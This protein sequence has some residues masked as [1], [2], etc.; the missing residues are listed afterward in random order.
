MHS[1]SLKTIPFTI[2]LL[3]LLHFTFFI[4]FRF[5]ARVGGGRGGNLLLSIALIFRSIAGI[6]T[7]LS[8]SLFASRFFHL[9]L[10]FLRFF[11]FLSEVR[12]FGVTLRVGC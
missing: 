11:D 8:F 5:R 3:L 12:F 2:T 6:I 4:M 7:A 1:K 10:L 9:F